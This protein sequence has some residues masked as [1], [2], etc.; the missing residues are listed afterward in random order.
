MYVDVFNDYRIM[1][2]TSYNK[3]HPREVTYN[4]LYNKYSWEQLF[5]DHKFI[6]FS[7]CYV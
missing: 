7:V 6:L 1:F 2:E 5:D 4:N 3:K